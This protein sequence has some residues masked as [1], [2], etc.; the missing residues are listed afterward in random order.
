[1]SA[2]ATSF[3]RAAERVPRWSSTGHARVR[4]DRSPAL[5]PA[6]LSS[7]RAIVMAARVELIGP[8]SRRNHTSATPP[9]LTPTLIVAIKSP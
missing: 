8:T 2:S 4:P 9:R 5:L 1:M 6:L 7:H 3:T